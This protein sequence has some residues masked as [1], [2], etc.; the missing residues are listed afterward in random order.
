MSYSAEAYFKE[1]H[2]DSPV[3]VRTDADVDAL[4]DALLAEP[5]SNSMANL[6]IVERIPGPKGITD[7]ELGVGVDAEDGVGGLWYLGD[8]DTWF[9]LGERSQRDTVFYCFTDHDREFPIN[10]IIPLDLVRQ[11]TKEFL[12]SG[13]R[14]PTCVQWQPHRTNQAVSP[15]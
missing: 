9:S 4:I 14:R 12:A 2:R 5:F 1:E 13:G 6:Y 10:S 11:A 3:I 8:G 15:A 7:H